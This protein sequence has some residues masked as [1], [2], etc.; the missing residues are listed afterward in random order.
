MGED[1]HSRRVMIAGVGAGGLALAL[2]ACGG[3]DSATTV[4]TATT[5]PESGAPAAAESSAAAAPQAG[6][7]LA[8]T[9]DIPVGGGTIFKEQKI[10]VVQPTE[11]QFKAFS[12]TC[13]HQGC[14]VSSVENGQI[15]CPCHKSL[16][17]VED[18]SVAQGPATKPL[19]EQP[20]KVEGDQIMLA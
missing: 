16:F 9:A 14:S 5:A 19:P 13:T 1:F 2:T 8:K 10:V 4:T 15:V 6:G 17:K 3:G 11:G 18:G 7:A 20:I 12:A